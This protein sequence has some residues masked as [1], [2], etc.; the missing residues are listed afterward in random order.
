MDRKRQLLPG[1]FEHALD[2]L[3]DRELAWSVFDARYRNDAVGAPAN[4]PAL[5]IK[6]VRFA[7]SQGIVGSRTIERVCREH[8][9]CIALSGDQAPHFT[10]VAG[11]IATLGGQVER[12]VRPR[13]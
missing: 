10:A 2:C 6:I 9:T 8:V 1:T 13:S 7:Y 5:L 12:R 3:V 4:P 11:C